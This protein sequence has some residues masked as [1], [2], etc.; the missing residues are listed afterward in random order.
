MVSV[1][2]SRNCCKHEQ[3]QWVSVDS[4][5]HSTENALTI[6]N[7]EIQKMRDAIIQNRLVLDMITSERGGVCKM[8]GMSCCFRIPDYSGNINNIITHMRMAVKQPERVKN[9]WFGWFTNLR[10]GWG[11]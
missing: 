3:N 11:Y 6:I 9:V 1:C 2:R 5:G 7:K 10:R 8:L 4:F